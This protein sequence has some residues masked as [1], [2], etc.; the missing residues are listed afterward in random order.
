M[1]HVAVLWHSKFEQLSLEER[2]RESCNGNCVVRL[3]GLP[4]I[5][6]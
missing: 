4:D 2:T 3:L 5:L 6:V 1:L